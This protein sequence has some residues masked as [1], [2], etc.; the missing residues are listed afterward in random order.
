MRISMI[1]RVSVLF[2]VL[3]IGGIVG[4]PAIAQSFKDAGNATDVIN[5][6]S[7]RFGHPYRRGV[8]PTREVHEQ[9]KSWSLAHHP[10]HRLVVTGKAPSEFAAHLKAAASSGSE[11]LSYGGGVDSI[12]VTSGVPKVYVVFWGTQWGTATTASNGIMSF[13]GDRK[14]AAPY[15]QNWIRGLGTNN[16][17]WSGVMTQYCDGPSVAYG[18]TSCP[19]GAS[20]I[21]YPGGA[22]LGGA[23]AG[24]WYDHSG[25]APSSATGYQIAQEAVKAAAY[26]GN[27]TSA[28]NRYAQ[29]IIMSPTG[30]NPDGYKTGGFCAWH[31][32]NGDTTLTGGAA[33][34]SYGDIAFTNMP[35]VADA[36]SSCGANFVSSALDGFSIV[37]GHEYAETITDQNPSGGWINLTNS[38]FNGE[39][40]GD[41]CAWISSG[42][43]ASA[44][45]AMT[46]GS[47][48][49]QST[50]S[51]DTNRCDISHSIITGSGGA[52]SANFTFSVTGLSVS[53][54]DQSIDNGGSIG[55]YAWNFGDGS[56]AST[57]NPT[58]AYASV[59]TYT[60]TETVTDLLNSATSTKTLQVTVSQS[61]GIV[62][63]SYTYLTNGL[64]V[65]F[66]DASTDVGGSISTYSWS[67][68]DNTTS[69]SA[70][71]SHTYARSGTYTVTETVRDSVSASS[72]SYSQSVTIT[73]ASNPI[74]NGGFEAGTTTS[75]WV[76]TSGVIC[77]NSTCSGVTAHSGNWFA[78]LN[79]YGTTH[80][81][82]VDQTITL[83]A[84]KRT[85]TLS[86]YLHIDTQEMGTRAYDTL[87]VQVLN[88]SG[89][90]LGTLATYS[91]VNAA[92]GYALKSLSMNGYIGKTVKLRFKGS[93]DASLATSFIIDDVSMVVQ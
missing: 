65:T 44:R 85:A 26:F 77:S 12:G 18:A 16:E 83:P 8:V 7:P 63:A 42:Q 30:T 91:N 34:S 60:V 15:M 68:G 3:L 27:T 62:T 1:I 49:M 4:Y 66:K 81:D 84:G 31:D 47:F 69:T 75:P 82:T 87:A 56:S 55:A 21:G 41:E 90:V 93:E 88:T 13:S 51:N 29:Y 79:G 64:T 5:P 74:E 11:V 52:P 25:A 17:A 46:T 53:F 57:A 2:G 20:H 73:S 14:G 71:P 37:G 28:S 61:G 54:T 33:P 6:Y 38:S 43:G 92:T 39:E 67:F 59:G 19:T 23:L 45:V 10:D 9:M 48:A 86:F 40:N 70:N 22:A 24:V 89:T 72:N 50:W 32:W 36:G 80:V 78:W 35:Y 58:H 76:M